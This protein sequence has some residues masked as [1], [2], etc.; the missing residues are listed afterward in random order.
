M[1]GLN[2]DILLA[3]VNGSRLG[4]YNYDERLVRVTGNPS[5]IIPT[6]WDS[7]NLPYGFSQE[8]NVEGKLI[9]FRNAVARI[10][11]KSRVLVPVHLQQ[12]VID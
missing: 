7:F 11:P 1:E 10:T 4:L 6:H 2:P 8:A 5:V 12:F 9:P 3:G